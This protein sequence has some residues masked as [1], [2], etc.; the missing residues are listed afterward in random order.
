MTATKR[1][2]IILAASVAMGGFAS[3]A[4]ENFDDRRPGPLPSEWQCINAGGYEGGERIAGDFEIDLYGE[5]A[6]SKLRG[7]QKTDVRIVAVADAPSKGNVL[8]ISAERTALYCVKSSV[9]IRDGYVEVQGKAGAAKKHRYHKNPEEAS[10]GVIWRYQDS[11]NFYCVIPDGSNLK[12][13]RMLNGVMEKIENSPKVT[14]PSGKWNTIRVEFTAG[15]FKVF[16][17]GS[18][19]YFQG[20]REIQAAGAIGVV[21]E[22]DSFTQFD[23][24]NYGAFAKSGFED[25]EAMQL[26]P[27]SAPW[28]YGNTPDVAR[29]EYPLGTSDWQIARLRHP[30]NNVLRHTANGCQLYCVKSDVK[31]RNGYVEV[32]T[33]TRAGEFEQA[34]GLIWRFQDEQNYYMVRANS[35]E[36]EVTLFKF[37]DGARKSI[38]KSR[39]MTI[40]MNKWHMLRAE[41][42]DGTIKIILDGYPVFTATDKTFPNAGAVGVWTKNDSYVEFDNLSWGEE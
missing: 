8:Q 10:W 37:V 13:F 3:A 4:T 33:R 42:V 31:V 1:S 12:M 15:T 14:I 41:F 38:E 24:L 25:F 40:P 34:M 19:I 23:N 16:L 26:G 2:H 5:E 35:S 36:Q 17:N 29:P 22:G 7:P 39:H 20:D 18:Q 21:V 32:D 6:A 9:K 11:R 30:R 28:R 27:P